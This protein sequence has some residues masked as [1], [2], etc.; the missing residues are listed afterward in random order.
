[1]AGALDGIKVVDLSQVAAVPM[2]ARLLADFGADVIHVEHPKRGDSMR[3]LQVLITETIP[4][5]GSDI[6][7]IWQNY[8]RN[9]RGLAVDLSHKAGQK[10]IHRLVEEADVFLSNLRPFELVK[11]DM[12][13]DTLSGLNQGLIYGN[14]TSYG[15]QGP[16]KNTPA[17]DATAYF[18]RT[19]ITHRLTVPGMPP[20]GGVGAFGDNIAGLILYSGIMTAL[21]A[22]DRTGVGQEIDVSLFQAGL[23]QLSFE[24]AASLATGKD[25]LEEAILA[26][27]DW[28]P[29]QDVRE[30]VR[31]PIAVPYMTKDD[32][33][34]LLAALQS[35]NYWGKVCRAIG[36][37]DLEKDPRFESDKT[38]AD[39]R[40]D[41]FHLLEE[42]FKSKTLDE[43]KGLLGEIPFAPYQNYLEALDDPQVRAN[44]F[45][46]RFEH[47]TEGPMEILANPINLSKTPAVARTPAPHIGQHTEEILLQYGYTQEDVEQFRQQGV[48][49]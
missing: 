23:F 40:A 7:Y 34:F 3:G 2:T 38:R 18:A 42:V 4:A 16:D 24:L 28:T 9:K 6:D 41:L 12:G 13:Y 49:A 37:E 21:Y 1:M 17:Y 30:T 10:I 25:Y 27:E 14:L 44:G 8:N 20:I 45:L 15:K 19:G 46:E 11:F 22:R 47:P 39:N 5:L 31:N 35:D 26:R 36:R 32:R 48:V 43:W 29:G 33:W